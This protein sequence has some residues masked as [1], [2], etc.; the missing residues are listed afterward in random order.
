MHFY[1]DQDVARHYAQRVLEHPLTINHTARNSGFQFDQRV[2]ALTVMS[3][4][5]WMQGLPEQALQHANDAVEEALSIDHALS[6]CYAIANG[7]APV[8]FWSGDKIRARNWTA[9]LRQRSDERSLYFW[10][11]FADV[12]Q[13]IIS[14]EDGVDTSH[15]A[16]SSPA[17]GT[18]LRET[19]CTV[20]PEFAD[21]VLIARAQ[22]GESG[23]C[24]AE[25][26]RV[27]GE[28]NWAD[29]DVTS[30]ES[31]FLRGIEV[32]RQQQALSWELRC[33]MSLARLWHQA[34][35][36][37]RARD[38]LGAVLQRFHDGFETQDLRAARELML[39]GLK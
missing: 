13:L 18:L 21:D 6:L 38:T 10:Q 17:V 12:F 26:L 31:N 1:G 3:R 19:L 25:L 14:L 27:T 16:L 35:A 4:V 37:T 34:G 32:S 5:L 28:R 20:R 30:A 7:A 36:T 11:A 39:C 22:R 29:G 23:W 2:A 33:C 15:A 24:T 9:L 8:A